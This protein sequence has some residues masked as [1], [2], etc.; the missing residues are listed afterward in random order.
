MNRSRIAR[1]WRSIQPGVDWAI[2]IVIAAVGLADV[3]VNSFFQPRWL[4]VI[5]T[6]VAFVPLGVRRRFP[7]AVLTTV[8]AASLVLELVIGNPKNP[9]QFG[10]EVLV[11]WLIAAY[12]AGAYT[13]GRRHLAA[14]GI[15]LLIAVVWIAGS[16]ALGA[17]NENTVPAVLL[18]AVVWMVGR[19]VRRR[20]VQV[21][22]LDDRARQL[23]R[24]REGKVR[25]L[26]AEERTRI[27]RELHDVVA[28]SV[29]VM[30]VQAQA[31]PRLEND[32]Q[33]TA[34]TFESIES[35]GREA[36]V[37]LRRLLGILRT[38]DKQLAVGPQP[39]LASLEGLIEQVRAAGLPVEL[40]TEGDRAVLPPGLDLSAYRII[41]E[42]LTNTLKHAGPAH[43]QV[44]V[45][46]SNAAV[47][48]E[49][50]DNGLGAPSAVNGAGHGLIGMRERTA[51]YGG[52]LEVGGRPG[53][54]YSVRAQLP[55]GGAQ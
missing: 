48:L 1:R 30:V 38:E 7:L 14:V 47:E 36:L 9:D 25:A 29:S 42:A 26:V 21:E 44:V 54:G 5:V 23:E 18:C 10:L 4:A 46:Y 37:E 49:I 15:G 17:S 34:A 27:A 51:L 39:G 50:V 8:G 32:P 3:L 2:A 53:G 11:A 43:A 31:G 24:E 19:A 13:K 22:V 40:R 41:Q 6:L 33:R 55:L 35:S 16:L 52:R 45:R 28:H 12:S 20:D